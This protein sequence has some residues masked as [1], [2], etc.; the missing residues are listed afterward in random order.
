MAYIRKRGNTYKVEVDRQGV[1][2]NATFKT[3]AAAE[4]WA[5][6]I[7]AEIEAGRTG[8]LI[9]GKT[10]ANA[11][12][13]YHEKVTPQKRGHVR[14]AYRI[15]QMLR[16]DYAGSTLVRMPLQA[17]K[18][19][20]VSKWKNDRMKEVAEGT[21]GREW[22]LLSNV[23]KKANEWGWI[24]GSPLEGVEPPQ[25]PEPRHRVFSDDEV[26]TILAA[27]DYSP[28][29]PPPSPLD[30][31]Q[32]VGAAFAFAL[33]TA[34]RAGEICG[35]LAKHVD[36]QRRIVF[37]PMTKNGRSREVPLSTTAMWILDGLTGD[38]LFG[39][40]PADLTVAFVKLHKK[41]GLENVMFRDTG[42]RR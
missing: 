10:L 5:R 6:E 1:K 11:L 8:Q 28:T 21:F 38:P 4:A 3:K 22:A 29:N 31:M 27:C 17:I 32:K 34:C 9:P 40:K 25:D 30:H 19:Q 23:F 18:K 42:Q 20:N 2:R 16:S 37:L 14:E 35:I 26:A 33:E 39:M 12:N 41:L 36:R 7:E 15:K 24:K 13:E